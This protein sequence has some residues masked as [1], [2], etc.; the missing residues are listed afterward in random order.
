M[1]GIILGVFNALTPNGL[2]G[3]SW[4]HPDDDSVNYMDLD[5]WVTMAKKLEGAGIDFLF[6]A[7]SYG[8]PT[9]DGVVPDVALREAVLM[10]A[11]DAMTL[12][13]ALA[14]ATEKLG[15]VVTASTMFETPYSNA[16]RFATL[17]H[18]SKGRAGWN[19]VT[20]ASA[21]SAARMFGKEPTAHDLRYDI[22]DDF[23]DLSLKFFEGTWEDDAVLADKEAKIYALPERVH[24]V[25]H[26]GPHF[27]SD[28]V[29]PVEPSPQRTPVLFQAGSSGRGRAFAARNA[30]CVLLQGSDVET[31]AANVTDIRQQAAAYGREEGSIKL[32]VGLTILTAP[33]QEE[34]L[35]KRET[36]LNLSP[37]DVAALSY[38][39]LTGLNLLDMDLDQP[40]G[41]VA[42]EQGQSNIE[43]FRGKNGGPAP[44]VREVLDKF[45]RDGV[46]GL[47]LVGTPEAVVDEMETY[48]TQTGVDGFI[49][50]PYI[51]PGNYD[52][53][54]GLIL[55]VL[56]ER[57]LFHE[58]TGDTLRERLFGTIDPHLP[59]DYPGVKVRVGRAKAEVE[60]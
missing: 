39:F 56:R 6:L 53:L 16:R 17:D 4:R 31:V 40:I 46:R 60:R 35:A 22:G 7:D 29:F 10:P 57:G 50:E 45:R 51:N 19:I 15:L 34:A 37:I 47:V 44:T 1:S 25:S 9:I 55:P 8:I 59:A 20:S 52:D 38:S 30:E 36:M 11:G 41:D 24:P 12:V 3:A 26:R 43:R 21:A 32:L 48:L 27:S 33:T 13:A 49:I 14:G 18:L 23:L 58:K 2:S 28:G 42:A 5:R 54:I